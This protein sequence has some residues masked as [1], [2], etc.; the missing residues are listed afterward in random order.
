MASTVL[1]PLTRT[2]RG[3]RAYLGSGTTP[4]CIR[5]GRGSSGKLSSVRLAHTASVGRLESIGG[6]LPE[7][8]PPATT[9]QSRWKTSKEWTLTRQ[10]FL[11]M[12]DGK[13]SFI[14][15]PNFISREVAHNFEDE[16]SPRL[17]PYENSTGPPVLKVGLAQFEYQAQSAE[18]FKNRSKDSKGTLESLKKQKARKMFAKLQDRKATLLCPCRAVIESSF[19]HG[20]KG[21]AGPARQSSRRNSVARA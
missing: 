1:R 20:Q 16:L 15:Q 11:D 19:R 17:V 18:D 12:L 5:T 2:T 21:W 13:I 7:L 4:Q 3:F 14:R 6:D 10:A 8:G 9:Y